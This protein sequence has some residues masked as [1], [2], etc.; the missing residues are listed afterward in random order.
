MTRDALLVVLLSCFLK[1]MNSAGIV[2]TG[3]ERRTTRMNQN[4]SFSAG[5]VS[6]QSDENHQ[7]RLFSKNLNLP[8]HFSRST[9]SLEGVLPSYVQVVAGTATAG[10]SGENLLS[11]SAQLRAAMP[12]VDTN[13]NIYIP[14]DAGF[15][16]RKVNQLGIITTF[17]GTGTGTTSGTAGPIDSVYFYIPYSIVG[18]TAGTFLYISD[19]YYVWKYV[20]ATG[21]AF[22]FAGSGQGYIGDN[23]P[24]TAAKLFTP[25]GLWLTTSGDLYIADCDNHAIRK[26]SS[27]NITTVAG[28]SG[29][30]SFSGD[31][32]P[33]LAATLN[34]PL[35]VFMNT[36]G[37]L[38][39]ADSLNYRIRMVD[40]NQIISTFAGSGTASPFNGNNIN[41]VVANI[42]TPWDVKGDSLGNVYIADYDNC[43]I[44][45][46][47]ATSKTISTVFGLPGSCGFTPGISD[48]SSSIRNP[49]GLWLDSLSRIYFSDHN[50]IHR[51]VTEPLSYSTTFMRLIAGTSGT[52]FSGDGG[53]RP[54][55]KSAHEFS[56]WT[57]TG[58]FIFLSKPAAE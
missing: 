19:Q 31:H 20:F 52:G 8:T 34:N 58:M 39:I 29:V 25:K 51:S 5:N 22:V 56:G 37:V 1:H 44:R 41:A 21:I 27:G 49:M 57:V 26:V 30:D 18:D 33:A 28:F 42:N 36:N 53:P 55:L 10:F 23:G 16:I 50:A 24:A 15:R 48:R 14:E 46:V 3:K 32:G 35:S 17:G 45:M 6:F 13:G 43:I 7:T 40:T 4:P 54:Q 38:F 9:V 11:T 12:W 2:R 47:D